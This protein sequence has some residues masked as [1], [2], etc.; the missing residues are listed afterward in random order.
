MM[1]KDSKVEFLRLMQVQ[2]F[3]SYKNGWMIHNATVSNAMA[4]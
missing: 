3:R 1:F 2:W 4:I